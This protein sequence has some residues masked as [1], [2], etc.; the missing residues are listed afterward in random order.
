MQSKLIAFNNLLTLNFH[1]F[2]EVVLSAII[3]ETFSL[4]E[5]GLWGGEGCG[6]ASFSIMFVEISVIMQPSSS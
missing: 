5:G 1:W 6:V 4:Y 2:I 3:V